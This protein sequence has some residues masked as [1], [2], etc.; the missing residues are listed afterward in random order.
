MNKLNPLRGAAQS[1]IVEESTF[2]QNRVYMEFSVLKKFCMLSLGIYLK[3]H[4]I[5]YIVYIDLHMY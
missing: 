5:N 1:T 4:N 3:A 2:A